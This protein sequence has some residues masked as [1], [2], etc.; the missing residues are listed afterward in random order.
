MTKNRI[1]GDLQVWIDARKRFHL[2]HAQVQ[3]ARELGMNPRRFGKL[4]NHKQEPWKLPLPLY[5]EH[6]YRRHFGRE[7]PAVV[8]SIEERARKIAAKKA[9]R[10]EAKRRREELNV[11]IA[12]YL[13]EPWDRLR[14]IAA[15]ADHMEKTYA[16][17]LAVAERTLA[18]MAERGFE[19]KKVVVDVNELA[20]WCAEQGV[21]IDS[22]ARSQYVAS[23]LQA[24]HAP[25]PGC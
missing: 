8:V 1:P 7:R 3:M 14:E 23:L 13:P 9:E 21:S 10:R 16:E 15:D 24:R 19:V 17:W 18:E 2:S 5:I 4:A 12:W 6:L 20:A 25:S 11:G 22:A